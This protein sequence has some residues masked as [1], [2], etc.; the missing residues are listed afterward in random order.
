MQKRSGTVEYV[1]LR[2]G[3]ALKHEFAVRRAIFLPQAIIAGKVGS[4]PRDAW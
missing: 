1:R 3:V 2:R 4:S